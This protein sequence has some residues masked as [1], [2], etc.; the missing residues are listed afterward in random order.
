MRRVVADGGLVASAQIA[1]SG[2]P[3]QV[4]MRAQNRGYTGDRG[5]CARSADLART[6]PLYNEYTPKRQKTR[7][8][9][10]TARIKP[11]SW[12]FAF[13]MSKSVN[14]GTSA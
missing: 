3:V 14:S 11:T 5:R 10:T 6:L 4:R 7:L 8:A 9:V 12:S 2:A 1:R 13:R